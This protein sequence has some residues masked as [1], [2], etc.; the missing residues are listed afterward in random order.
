VDA[1]AD[2]LAGSAVDP[3]ASTCP[4]PG[5]APLHAVATAKKT[6]HDGA[7]TPLLYYA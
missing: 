2:A 1:L 3:L 5:G 6:S 4:A 7:R